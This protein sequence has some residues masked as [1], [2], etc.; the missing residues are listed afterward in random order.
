MFN[1]MFAGRFRDSSSSLGMNPGIARGLQKMGSK[2]LLN[3]STYGQMEET[4]GS[5]FWVV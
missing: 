1:G 2:N 3:R 4:P 5:L